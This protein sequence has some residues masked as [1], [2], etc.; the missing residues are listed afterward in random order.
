MKRVVTHIAAGLLALAGASVQAG[1]YSEPVTY[2]AEGVTLKGYLAYDESVE[3]KRPG[4]LVV[5]EWW[6]QN[7][8]IRERARMLAEEGY[9]ALAVDMYGEGKTADH[10]KQA[11]EFAGAVRQSWETGR[12]RFQAA[13]DVLRQHPT[14]DPERVAAIGYC[15]GGGVVLQM[16]REGAELDGVVSFHGSVAPTAEPAEPSDVEAAVLVLHGAQDKMVSADQVQ[17]FE[18]E[19]EQA[20][21]DHEVVVYE[22]ATHGFTNPNADE[23]ARKFEIPVGYNADADQDSWQRMLGFFDKIFGE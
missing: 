5:H 9:T 23:Y 7:E 19:M 13:L 8:Y 21:A 14:V 17:A 4:V 11:G 12:A 1:L 15:F 18:Q 22:D 16:A 2:N 6:G 3:G 10:P 20:G